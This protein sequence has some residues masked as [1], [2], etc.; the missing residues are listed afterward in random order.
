MDIR[1]YATVKEMPNYYPFLTERSFRH[2]ISDNRNGI[3]ECMIRIGRRVF[4][5]LEKFQ[6][7]MDKNHMGAN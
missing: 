2:L 7:W 6:N 1:K 4:F 5:D 3:K